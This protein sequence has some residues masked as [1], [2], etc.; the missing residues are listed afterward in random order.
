VKKIFLKTLE[1]HY[2][3]KMSEVGVVQKLLR[4]RN[5]CIRAILELQ[6]LSRHPKK[7]ISMDNAHGIKINHLCFA[8]LCVASLSI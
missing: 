4:R 6:Y 2:A 8:S 7:D 5:A 1:P 3:S